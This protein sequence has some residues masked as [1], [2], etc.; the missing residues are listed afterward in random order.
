MA[1]DLLFTRL[2]RAAL[3]FQSAAQQFP[4]VFVVEK[5]IVAVL[6]LLFHATE[7]LNAQRKHFCGLLHGHH[8][9][10]PVQLLFVLNPFIEVKLL[11]DG[12]GH[13]IDDTEL[14]AN[15]DL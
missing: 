1:F 4:V 12:R 5:L 14:F 3:N 7:I 2:Y 13:N 10:L 15:T 8:G 11:P 9:E 6:E